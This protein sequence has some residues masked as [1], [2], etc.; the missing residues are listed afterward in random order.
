M[1]YVK[2]GTHRFPNSGADTLELELQVVLS[3]YVG[4]MNRTRVHCQICE[5]LLTAEPSIWPV[6]ASFKRILE[7]FF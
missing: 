7:E 4:A 6:F 2:A 1:H 5:V 3:R